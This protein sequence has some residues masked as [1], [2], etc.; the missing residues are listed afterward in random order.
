MLPKTTGNFEGI[1]IALFPPLSFLAS[2]VDLMVVDGAKRNGE[3][4]ADLSGSSPWIARSDVVRVRGQAPADEAR[5]TG[6]EAE[7]LLG[8][9]SL[10][11]AEGED[12]LVD[13]GAR[14]FGGVPVTWL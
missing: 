5:L 11:F 12:A 4:I 2:G 13:L 6:D 3:L 8:A 14:S 1:D 7:M 10:R 9:Y